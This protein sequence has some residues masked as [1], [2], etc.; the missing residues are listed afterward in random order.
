VSGVISIAPA[1]DF[2]FADPAAPLIPM[3][4]INA[5]TDLLFGSQFT[6]AARY[7]EV[8]AARGLRLRD[9]VSLW[10]IGNSAH[11]PPEAWL[12]SLIDNFGPRVG[13]DAW[14]PF[15]DAALGHMIR[16]MTARDERDRRMPASHYDGRLVDGNRVF[17]PQRAGPPTEFVPFVVD[18]RW[19]AYDGDP[20]DSHV[21][22][23]DQVADFAA[24][25]RELRPTGHLLGPRMANPI[26]GYNINFDGGELAVTFND[27][28][29]RY[30]SW[31]GYLQRS[32]D[33]IAR[34]EAA[35]VYVAPRGKAALIKLL[36]PAAFDAFQAQGLAGS[37]SA[38]R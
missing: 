7:R 18:P 14:A 32:K 33:A 34:L 9:R 26:G 17:F 29:R 30:G 6:I 21:L 4:F 38:E 12:D 35:G 19:D 15:I 25:A 13:G 22:N 31:D 20:L 1:L 28:G 16:V 3:I 10:S 23:P 24:V 8:L 5:E 11:I 37:A 36:D 2:S 27:L